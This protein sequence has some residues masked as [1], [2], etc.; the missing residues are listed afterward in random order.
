VYHGGGRQRFSALPRSGGRFAARI[1]LSRTIISEQYLTRMYA[2]AAISTSSGRTSVLLYAYVCA[3]A[4]VV[5]ELSSSQRVN[6]PRRQRRF[7]GTSSV[8]IGRHS[9]SE[10]TR[11]CH[12]PFRLHSNYD[13]IARTSRRAREIRLC[14]RVLENDADYVSETVTTLPRETLVAYAFRISVSLDTTPPPLPH[15]ITS[16]HSSYNLLR[17]VNIYFER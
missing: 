13:D 11:P 8:D 1:C 10:E 5:N 4:R 16:I 3:H 2:S 17:I 12:A 14:F 9:V 6:A 15:S 7:I